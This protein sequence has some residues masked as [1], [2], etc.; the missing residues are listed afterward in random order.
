MNSEIES[1]W[2]ISLIYSTVSQ[3]QC[4]CASVHL[5]NPSS[6]FFP[7]SIV[8]GLSSVIS[9]SSLPWFG[10]PW[11][12]LHFPSFLSSL[13]PL[14]F[15]F[16]CFSLILRFTRLQAI[17][18]IY[19]KISLFLFSLT[20]STTSSMCLY[21]RAFAIYLI[22]L[23]LYLFKHFLGL[24]RWFFAYFCFFFWGGGGITLAYLGPDVRIWIAKRSGEWSQGELLKPFS[25]KIFFPF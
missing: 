17:L 9:P 12:F 15:H 5:Q 16:P 23:I 25:T 13:P 8:V 3:L 14:S 22:Q 6:F 24:V 4:D 20:K 19:C 21:V 10:P 1:L 7:H 2:C 11:I 18:C